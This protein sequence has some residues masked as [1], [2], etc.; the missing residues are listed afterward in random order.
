MQAAIAASDTLTDGDKP[1]LGDVA[2]PV[3]RDG[4]GGVAYPGRCPSWNREPRRR[5]RRAM[6]QTGL[7]IAVVLTAALGLMTLLPLLETNAWWVRYLDFIRLYVGGALLVLL[8][9][10]A[11]A[12]AW[13]SRTGVVILAACGGLAALQVAKLHVYTPVVAPMAAVAASCPAGSGFSVMVANVKK[14]N[15]DFAAF[16]AVVTDADPD[17]LLV[18]ETDQWWDA[19]LATLQEPYR[20]SIESLPQ[21]VEYYGLHLFSKYPLVD[22]AVEFWFETGTPSVTADVSLPAGKIRFIGIHPRPP[23]SFKHSTALRDGTMAQAALSAAGSP[24][25]TILA[26]DFNA[27]PWERTFRRMLRVGGLLDPRVGRGYFATYDAESPVLAWPLDHILFQDAIELLGFSPLPNV[28]SDHYPV[29]A[30]L[31]LAPD[32]AAGQAG[33]AEEPG[34]REELRRAI[35]AA[36][37]RAA[38]M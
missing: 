37:D 3:T 21:A 29:M 38:D 31:C 14:G 15:R 30:E 8:A 17:I 1:A 34:D 13:Q 28:D 7:A 16:S 36:H 24:T 2:E 11:A 26:G 5:E 35:A 19:Q 20:A 6:R 9:V 12:G 27:V 10:L 18:L 22:P 32:M 33:P 23:Q 25:P 4:Q